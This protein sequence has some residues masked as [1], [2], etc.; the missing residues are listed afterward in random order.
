RFREVEVELAEGSDRKDDRGVGDAFRKVLAALEKSGA[1]RRLQPK[2]AVA[3]GLSAARPARHPI[4]VDRRSTL[5]VLVR[6]SLASSLDRLLDHDLRL[7]LD[8]SDPPVEDVHQA[9]VATR[10]LRADLKTFRPALDEIWAGQTRNDLKWVGGILGRVRDLDVLAETLSTPRPGQPMEAAGRRELLGKLADQR[11][12]A[13]RQLVEV[14]DSDP[15]YLRL[16]DRLHAAATEP[17]FRLGR[18]TGRR[19]GRDPAPDQI[20]RS[21]MPR[22]ITTSWRSLRRTVRRAGKRPTNRQLHQIRIRSKQLRYACEIAAPVVGKRSR[23]TAVAAARIQRVLGDHHDAVA[24]E[25]WL[26]N[27]TLG[28]SPWAAFAAGQMT[29][30]LRRRRSRLRRRW[31][32]AWSRLDRPAVRR[33]LR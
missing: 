25:E 26:W 20:A 4:E 17:P 23:R 15:R 24:A 1:Q 30:D 14:I 10:R 28:A 31:L 18:S 22:L 8:P 21:V 3:L 2:I 32:R 33:W 6:R 5:D 7:R 12:G 29:A 9:R 11:R 16:L 19:S 27:E 13:S